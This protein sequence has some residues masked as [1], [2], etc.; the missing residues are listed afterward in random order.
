MWWRPRR[1]SR[2][3][4]E[5]ERAFEEV[6][7]MVE[8][9]FETLSKVPG[10]AKGRETMIEGPYF[11][12]FSITIGPDGRPVVQEFGNVKPSRWGIE[13]SEVRKPYVETHLDSKAGELKLVA[14][15]PGVDKNA[16]KINA[17]EDSVTIQA[18]Q[19]DRKYNAEVKLPAKVDPTS[20]KANYRN[21]VLEVTLKLK[22][23]PERKG[24]EIKVE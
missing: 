15:L 9:M 1:I 24:Y 10:G 3:F 21:G 8:R 6:D 23:K 13:K 2:L 7:E 11:Y 16:I 4:D 14:E 5:V 19:E 20:A 18:E 12:G 22:E 17:T